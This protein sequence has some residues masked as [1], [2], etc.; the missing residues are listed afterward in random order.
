MVP[1]GITLGFVGCLIF[2]RWL[3]ISGWRA[4]IWVQICV[5][6]P[7]IIVFSCLRGRYF[8]VLGGRE[9]R[10]HDQA[11]K[12]MKRSGQYVSRGD[13]GGGHDE[14]IERKGAWEKKKIK[15]KN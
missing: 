14:G 5:L 1:I 7:F 11:K 9:A 2:Q 13:G 4:A 6:A 8:N 12:M 15:K 3:G 10:L